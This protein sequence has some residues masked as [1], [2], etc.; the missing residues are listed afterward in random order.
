MKRRSGLA[1]SLVL[2]SLAACLS[3]APIVAQD[4]ELVSA[5]TGVPLPAA[6]YA[7]KAADPFAFELPNGV[8]GRRGAV[9][10]WEAPGAVAQRANGAFLGEA[11]LPVILALFSDSPEPTRTRTEIDEAVFTG[12]SDAGTFSGFYTEVS[13]G[14]FTVVGDVFPWVRTGITEAETAGGSRG[15]GGDAQVAQ[16]LAEAVALLDADVDWGRYDDDGP[17]G[18]PNSGDDDGFVDIVAIEYLEVAGSCGGSSG[19][20][21]HRYGYSGWAGA[22]LA[23]NDASANGGPIF[24]DGYITQSVSDC[25]GENIQGAATISHEY[26]HAL[27]LPDYYHAIN[28]VEAV[29]RRWV[30]GCWSLMAAGAWGCGPVGSN[31]EAFGP[32]HMMSF[33]KARLGWLDFTEVPSDVR[34]AVYE[35]GPVQTTGD[36][37]R[38]PL[39]DAGS[40]ALLVEYRTQTGFDWQLPASGVLVSRHDSDAPLRPQS[41]KRY[42]LSLLEA[43]GDGALLRTAHEG[44][45]RGAP[46]DAFAVGGAVG[47][48][49]NLTTP[50]TR[51]GTGLSSTVTIHEMRVDAGRA[52]IRLST[53]REPA[54]LQPDGPASRPGVSPAQTRIPIFG[55]A[56]P[57]TVSAVSLPPGLTVSSEEDEIVLDGGV[58]QVGLVSFEVLVR[59]VLGRGGNQTIQLQVDPFAPSAALLLAPFFGGLGRDPTPLE[60]DALDLGGNGNGRYD[61]GDLRSWLFGG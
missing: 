54:V 27:G 51:T 12:P 38:I 49:H 7:R 48:L 39:D 15:L 42:F 56:L 45:D 46:G 6:Y 59:D 20:W 25:S 4:L 41:G 8:F 13:R 30:L 50:S 3:S 26:G 53:A 47:R 9:L 61:V 33:S 21:P 17:D 40:Q 23:T 19:I 37:L 16:Y 32:T 43:D 29:D 5:R 28:G 34:N 18:L 52:R 31:R 55:G 10:P 11:R 58:A 57:Y 14:R 22:P 2:G 24:V 36:A 35:L 1:P 44:G 60:L